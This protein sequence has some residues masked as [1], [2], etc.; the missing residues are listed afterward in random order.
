MQAAVLA[1]WVGHAVTLRLG[2]LG[3]K[4]V[5]YLLI[6]G[7]D[8]IGG[9]DYFSGLLSSPAAGKRRKENG[10]LTGYGGVRKEISDVV[11]HSNIATPDVVV[12]TPEVRA[13]GKMFI[14]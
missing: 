2:D 10:L 13:L 4:Q 11:S 1:D 5:V 8:S 3:V 14:S 6:S 12:V 7:L 9:S